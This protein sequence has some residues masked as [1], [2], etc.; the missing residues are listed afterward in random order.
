ML[1]EDLFGYAI[2]SMEG[3]GGMDFNR[4]VLSGVIRKTKSI[5]PTFVGIKAP[6]YLEPV[7]EFA[8]EPFVWTV[9]PN[10]DPDKDGDPRDYLGELAAYCNRAATELAIMEELDSKSNGLCFDCV[11]RDSVSREVYPL[12]AV[13]KE[14]MVEG[15]LGFRFQ[16]NDNGKLSDRLGVEIMVNKVVPLQ[17]INGAKLSPDDSYSDE[18]IPF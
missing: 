13:D 18:D 15:Q 14:V 17:T 7:L 10:Y 11:V 6:D 2:F 3:H 16:R 4:V 9:N 8:L 12:I 5:S 1:I